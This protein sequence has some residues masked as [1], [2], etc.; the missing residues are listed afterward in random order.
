[1]V[2]EDIVT[3]SGVSNPPVKFPVT[4]VILKPA[5]SL[6]TKSDGSFDIA[7]IRFNFTFV[8]GGTVTT[9]AKTELAPPDF[10]APGASITGIVQ[11]PADATAQSDGSFKRS[12]E[13]LVTDVDKNGADFD[14]T[15]R[16]DA[17]GR[18][19]LTA[20]SKSVLPDLLRTPITAFGNVVV[21]TR[22]E[23]VNAE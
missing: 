21:A 1:S 5:P 23:T 16:V 14:G 9:V 2:T 18:A 22:G 19:T 12:Q 17:S 6:P 8:R 20:D 13:F 15:L 4:K 7:A 11:P 10:N 3:V